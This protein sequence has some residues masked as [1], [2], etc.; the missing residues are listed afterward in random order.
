[1]QEHEPTLAAAITGTRDKLLHQQDKS[2]VL[3]AS[4]NFLSKAP[5]LK[6]KASFLKF[7]SL[8][9]AIIGIITTAVNVPTTSW[10][11]A[12]DYSIPRVFLS[13]AIGTVLYFSYRAYQQKDVSLLK[14]QIV[15]QTI[16][17]DCNLLPLTNENVNSFLAKTA[18]T[19][20]NFGEH[21]NNIR[22][23]HVGS[24]KRD[25]HT[26]P[27][28]AFEYTYSYRV[29]MPKERQKGVLR[30]FKTT[31]KH[32]QRH[33][34]IIKRP[35]DKT[36]PITF[37]SVPGPFTGLCYQSHSVHLMNLYQIFTNNEQT[38][39]SSL[40]QDVI[41]ELQNIATPL[42]HPTIECRQDGYVCIS[43]DN[44]HP[45]DRKRAM[46]FDDQTQ[47]QAAI[48]SQLIPDELHASLVLLEK[49]DAPAA[50]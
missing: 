21:A 24:V 25:L 26:Y 30:L 34:F 35:S 19:S 18:F 2:D 4:N 36:N 17:N 23:S 3:A 6:S 32:E 41:L 13:V 8:L 49:L 15:E 40:T 9:I 47:Y 37:T 33:G 39:S 7:T 22:F 42:L 10:F 43:F 45:F 5:F 50:D 14:E 11:D 38:A 1:M 16:T 20:F 12:L 44:H 48:E 31:V 29:K 28:L 27:F 46:T